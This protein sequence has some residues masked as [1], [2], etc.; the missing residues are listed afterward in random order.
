MSLFFMMTI[1]I[2]SKKNVQ[3]QIKNL[4]LLIVIFSL[5][6][7]I[8]GL[9]DAFN[10][11]SYSDFSEIS[12]VPGTANDDSI[13]IDWN[14]A[15]I[16]SFFGIIGA[17]YLFNEKKSWLYTNLI[18]VS[19]SIFSLNIIFS[20]SRRGLI[21][22][23][24]IVIVLL[25]IKIYLFIH[26]N[27]T[28]V[29][30]NKAFNIFFISLISIF[31]LLFILLFHTNAKYKNNFLN[32][33]GSKNI[34]IVKSE[35]SLKFYRYISVIKHDLTI[36]DVNN[37]IWSVIY[38]P[39]DPDSGWGT[40]IHKNV[41]PLEGRNVE[42]V[43]KDAI[44]Y[45]MDYTCDPSYYPSINLSESFTLVTNIK[46]DSYE[47]YIASVFCFV[48][49]DFD[50]DVVSFG[51]G[52]S[53]INNNMVSGKTSAV[54]DYEN[55]GMWQK[56]EVD[57]TCMKGE[58]PLY[59]S[60]LKNGVKDF[61]GLKGQVI[62]AYPTFNKIT[63]HKPVYHTSSFLFFP[64]GLTQYLD[65]LKS[66]KDPVRKWVANFVSEDTIFYPYKSRI[67]LDTISN[68]F[69]SDRIL[70][71][72]FALKI[73]SKE[74]CFPQKIFG[75]GF[76]FLNWFGYYFYKDKTRSDYPHNPFLS[77]LLYSGILG[78]IIYVFFIYKVFFYYIKYFHEYK[79]FLIF[80]LIIFFFAFFSA[81]SPFDPPVMGFFVIWPF[82]INSIE[83]LKD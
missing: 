11:F 5:I 50:A 59:M 20:G 72:E 37:K 68:Q 49:E 52:A 42:I 40:R 57:F 28:L 62:F 25:I 74:Y 27:E 61:S 51:V 32:L 17:F 3:L 13:Y 6:T 80:F 19:F 66:D 7:S 54:Y 78:L 47:R 58:I 22:L 30:V 67:I 75:R 18:A 23:F 77:I 26:Q 8:L 1:V 21:L 56:L 63:E 71:W 48:S 29:L 36:S 2:T 76:N 79:I 82:Y 16:P 15:I 4:V 55:K 34:G 46:T 12:K 39:N 33:I 44:G 35:I 24:F 31:F 65:P 45:K 83:K 41:Y 73:F 43:P 10:I 53:S 64:M 70:R 60:F 14:F 69:V 38:D 9:L 81:G